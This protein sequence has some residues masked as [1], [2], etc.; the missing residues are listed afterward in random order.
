MSKASEQRKSRRNSS[1]V[2]PPG[3]R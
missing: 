1:E 2:A 3:L